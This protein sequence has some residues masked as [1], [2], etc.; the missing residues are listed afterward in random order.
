M[1][2]VDRPGLSQASVAMG[3]PGVGLADPDAAAL[4][5]LT[6]VLNNFGGRLFNQIRSREVRWL[7]TTLSIPSMTAAAEAR[8][9][10]R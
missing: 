3:E 9:Q 6:C 10:I 7:R 4:D 2:L 1:L 8:Y 5:V